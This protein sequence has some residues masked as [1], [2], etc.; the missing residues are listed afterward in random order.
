MGDQTG[1]LCEIDLDVTETHG[2]D[3]VA[4][5]ALVRQQQAGMTALT[6]AILEEIEEQQRAT[7]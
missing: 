4:L 5:L 1:L 7:V 2:D 6:Q 3:S